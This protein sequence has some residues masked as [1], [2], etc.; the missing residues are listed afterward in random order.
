[1]RIKNKIKCPGCGRM[2]GIIADDKYAKHKYRKG[3]KKMPMCNYSR[4]PIIRNYEAILKKGG[5]S[6]K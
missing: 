5:G 4:M 3:N 6:I 2:V 1:M